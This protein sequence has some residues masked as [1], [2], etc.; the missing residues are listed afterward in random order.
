VCL[1][2]RVTVV[3]KNNAVG[4]LWDS[5]SEP[6]SSLCEGRL[7]RTVPRHAHLRTK[8]V[9]FTQF[10]LSGITSQSKIAPSLTES[11][12]ESLRMI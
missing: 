2:V 6:R 8:T 10:F 7:E 1:L 5:L 3:D 9:Q 4:K 11:L 12:W